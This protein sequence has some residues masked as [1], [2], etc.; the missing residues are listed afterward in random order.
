MANRRPIDPSEILFKGAG[1]WDAIAIAVAGMAPTLAMN[2][3]PQEPAEHVGRVVPLVFV[4]STV[5]VLLVAWCLCAPGARASQCRVRL[6]LRGGDARAA[7]RLAGGVDAARDLSLLR[8]RR[9]RRVRPVRRQPAATPRCLARRIELRPDHRRDPGGCPAQHHSGAAR[10]PGS[11]HS[12]GHR[13]YC[14]GAAG[15]RG[16]DAGAARTWPPPTRHCAISSSRPPAS[17]PRRSRSACHSAC[18]R[19]RA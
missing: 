11:A 13:H 4:L 15:L 2:L 12:R 8:H 6:R 18:C 19:S 7:R 10:R 14:H 3:N 5:I 9:H 1:T 16:A 17:V